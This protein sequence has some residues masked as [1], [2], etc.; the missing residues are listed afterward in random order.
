MSM[1]NKIFVFDQKE[2][3][4]TLYSSAREALLDSCSLL[5]KPQKH[6]HELL[7]L[8]CYVDL[9]VLIPL[10]SELEEYL[11]ITSVKLMFD[12]SEVYR[13]GANYLTLYNDSSEKLTT[14]PFVVPATTGSFDFFWMKM[15]ETAEES[16]F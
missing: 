3:R 9:G 15:E 8:T 7:I 1:M 12:F 13:I 5:S 16:E 6:S 11:K 14:I 10:C 4:H 2:D